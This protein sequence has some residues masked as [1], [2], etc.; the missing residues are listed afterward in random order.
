LTGILT[1]SA[2]DRALAFDETLIDTLDGLMTRFAGQRPR[3]PGEESRAV[4]STRRYIDEIIER[5]QRQVI[6][7]QARDITLSRLA[8]R[9][10]LHPHYLLDVFRH[11]T[12]MSPLRYWRGRRIELALDELRRGRDICDVAV[13]LGFYDQAHLTR[14]FKSF[15]GVTPGRVA[16]S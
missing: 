11:Q 4:R 14:A 3:S 7:L 1:H 15:Y 2:T 10:S 8:E 5:S 16:V 13:R 12:G 6:D 9:V